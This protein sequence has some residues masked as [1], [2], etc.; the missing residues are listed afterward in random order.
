MTA[1]NL[2]R[3]LW[4]SYPVLILCAVISL[5]AGLILSSQLESIKTL[6]LIL[7]MVPPINGINNNV[8]SI[9][10]SRLTSALHIG[11]IEPKFGRQV[12]LRRNIRA[13]WIMSIGVFLFTS[14]IFF[15][16]S[17]IS[18]I[19]LFQSL[20][21]IAAFFLASMAAIG[22][23]IF[24]TI[25]LAFVSFSRGLDP[26]NVVIPIVTSIGDIA[27]VTCLIIAMKIIGV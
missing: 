5:T 4:E 15:I 24:C 6:P 17:L 1:Y 11:T 25:W 19:N 22:V 2:R 8:C 12:A 21:I 27:G 20:T 10:G 14:A 18:G 9:L 23:T 7:T 13:T 16:L 3:I 26:D